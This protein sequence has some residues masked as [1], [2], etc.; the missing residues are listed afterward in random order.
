MIADEAI[1]CVAVGTGKYIEYWTEMQ[2]DSAP[3]RSVLQTIFKR[4]R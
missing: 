2:N 4:E 1:S 3:K